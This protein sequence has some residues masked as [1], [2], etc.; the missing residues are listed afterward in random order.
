MRLISSSESWKYIVVLIFK[1]NAW[2]TKWIYQ[3]NTLESGA[4]LLLLGVI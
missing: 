4:S 2:T 1:I 3:V